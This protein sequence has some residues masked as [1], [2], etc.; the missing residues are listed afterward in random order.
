MLI[1]V[2]RMLLLKDLRLK[3]DGVVYRRVCSCM[4][5]D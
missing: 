3:I 4:R 1:E 2:C 5:I